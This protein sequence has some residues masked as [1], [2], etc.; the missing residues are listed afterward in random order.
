MSSSNAK[1]AELTSRLTEPYHHPSTSRSDPDEDDDEAIFAELEAEL[2]NDDNPA[3]REQGLE[4][5]KREMER[6]QNMKSTGHGRYDEIID[7]KEVIRTS[8][9]EPRCV[10]HFFHTNFKRCQIM[11]RH[12]AKLAPKY[13][14]TRL[15]RVFVENV[16]WLVE[17][18]GVKVLPCVICFIDG[19]SRARII[20]FEDLG[21]QDDFETATLEW[22]LLNIG[23]IQ[24]EQS[25][26]SGQ[27]TYGAKPALRQHIRGRD[28][29]DSDF[30]LD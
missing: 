28:D 26:S 3:L 1:V 16:P 15:I 17:K 13:F 20:G 9:N 5:L 21:N 7:E 10:I 6:L 23:V 11:D 8:A 30:D 14:S 2:E 22:K 24:K 29:D 27:I 25:T 19:V 12:L 4:Q 18:L